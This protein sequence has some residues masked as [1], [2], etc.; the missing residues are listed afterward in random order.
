MQDYQ[1]FLQTKI[2]RQPDSGLA[3]SPD[4][5]NPIMAGF[6]GDITI[7]GLRKGRAAI[8][9]DTGLGKTTMEVEWARLAAERSLIV[10]PLS[11]ARQTVR[12]ARE[13]LNTEVHYTRTGSDLVD[14]INI[15]NYE[16]ISKFN[17]DDFGAVVL[18]ESSILKSLDGKTRK[19][20]TELFQNVPFRLCAT[21][22]PAPNDIAEI[23]NHAEFLGVMTQAEM[24]SAFFINDMK[25]KDGTYRLKRHGRDK[26]YRWLASWGIAVR[27]PSDLGY[28]D[29][30]YDLPPITVDTLICEG[31]YT[32]EGMLPGF[33]VGR[34]SAMDAR[35]LRRAALPDRVE[36]IAEM[37]NASSEPWIVWGGLNEETDK[38]AALIGDA[39]N[40]Q[41]KMSVE[42]KVSALE[43]FTLGKTR[44]LISKVSIAGFGMNFQ[45][46]AN[47]AF[48]GLDYSWEQYYQAI[49]RIYR[50]G[51]T[52]PVSIFVVISEQERPIFER[53]LEKEKEAIGMVSKLIQH[54]ASYSKGE[55]L[56][57]QSEQFEYNEATTTRDKWQMMLGDS[58]ERI[59]E[60]KDN[61]VSLTVSSLPFLS[62]YTYTPTERDLGNSRNK[63]QFFTHFRYI[64][65]GL[66]RITKPG[67][68]CVIHVQQVAATKVNDGYI[69]IKDFRGDVI[70]AFNDAG[71][72]LH[73]EVTVDKNPQVQA[74]RT[75]SKGLLFVQ[76]HK[77]SVASRPALADY[78]L[79]FQKSGE[80]ET[81]VVPDVSNE[82]WIR[83]AH[84]VW[85]DI[86]E[87]DTLNV[88]I[89]R[90]DEDE[91]HL[92]P[93][94]LGLIERCIR[95]WSNKGEVVFDPFA[96]VG[97]TLV[98]AVKFN[99][100]GQGIE[101]K[102]E[103]YRQACK[104][105]EHAEAIAGFDLFSYAGIEIDSNG[106]V[107]VVARESE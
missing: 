107:E 66:L 6:R 89:A 16:M 57:T 21:A 68:N 17:P 42:D 51:Q 32:P 83:W 23:G 88:K 105:L 72:V 77:D 34:G 80:N 58:V 3:F 92:C 41:G 12:M 9:A 14:G 28:D 52:K 26:F 25:M 86:E 94:Q 35:K 47:M 73:G 93:L 13:M 85:Y 33:F 18:D 54:T 103:Y 99:R 82:E 50:F 8:F 98:E 53:V 36:R 67:R 97:S 56:V 101:L 19:L 30:G 49:R 96:G 84:P 78:L 62:L 2:I 29:T 91:R 46:C 45:H 95:L 10:A 40:V 79:I 22:T 64:I 20:L 39:V 44:V 11:V 71:W 90:S 43:S 75:K 69:G 100:V 87:T 61:S 5:L 31:E 38:L 1:A 48:C 15:T 81:P 76:M 60:I 102:P 55:I 74:I 7:W 37:V 27:K 104:N 24:L 59:N 63:D 106:Q 4:Q 65:D 70:R